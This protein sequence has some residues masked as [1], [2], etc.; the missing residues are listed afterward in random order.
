M[1]RYFLLQISGDGPKKI[2][3]EYKS[4]EELQDARRA[5]LL[6]L[7]YDYFCLTMKQGFI[8]K[9]EPADKRISK[10]ERPKLVELIEAWL[11]QKNEKLLKKNTTAQCLIPFAKKLVSLPPTASMT[12]IRHCMI[13]K[14][15]GSVALVK[16][17]KCYGLV[18]R[19]DIWILE[20]ESQPQQKVKL[21]DVMTSVKE[22]RLADENTDLA[23]VA[24][25]VHN[26]SIVLL[27]VDH[28]LKW[29]IS[30][31]TLAHA[32][33]EITRTYTAILSLE[34]KLKKLLHSSGLKRNEILD[35]LIEEE[36][37]LTEKEPKFFVKSDEFIFD[38]LTLM[39]MIKLIDARYDYIEQLKP[40]NKD[41]LLGE[42]NNARKIRN[43]LMHFRNLDQLSEMLA[44]IDSVAQKIN[45]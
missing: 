2:L 17:N 4:E 15:V 1:A 3:G 11:L 24:E 43:D 22:I 31:K 28:Q 8:S 34:T 26:F 38:K 25:D 45:G 42:L 30:P 37:E 14:G 18:K 44:K 6:T 32:F 29:A 33:Y 16:D 40:F 35:L 23:E 39:Q 27:E 9:V 36:P 12:E 41:Y 21:N 13:E 19:K 7:D 10:D 5:K 20:Q